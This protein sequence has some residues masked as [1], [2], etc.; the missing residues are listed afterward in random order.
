MGVRR[1]RV[2]IDE[3]V[4][5]GAT[6]VEARGFKDEFQARLSDLLIQRDIPTSWE[7]TRVVDHID[8][9]SHTRNSAGPLGARVAERVFDSFEGDL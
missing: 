8:A 4:L 3:V 2:N 7:S 6:P 1:I 5:E 9:G